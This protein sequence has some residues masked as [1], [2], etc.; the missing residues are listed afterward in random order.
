M[1]DDTAIEGLL[2]IAFFFAAVSSYVSMMWAK[3]LLTSPVAGPK[4]LASNTRIQHST[5]HLDQKPTYPIDERSGGVHGN[6]STKDRL[7][8]AGDWLVPVIVW[9]LVI[10]MTLAIVGFVLGDR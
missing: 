6:G 4:F 5:F 8:A 1:R 7:S 9:A 2:R 3:K 10:L